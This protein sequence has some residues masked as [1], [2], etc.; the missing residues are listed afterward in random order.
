VSPSQNSTAVFADTDAVGEAIAALPSPIEFLSAGSAAFFVPV[1]TD[2]DW[3]VG[4]GKRA[5]DL[6]VAIPALLLLTPLFLI[7]ALLIKL[8]SQGPAFFRQTR[9]GACGRS[10]RIL[11]F[12]TMTVMEN[13][14]DVIQAREADPRTTRFGQFL[15]RTSI[16]E[17]PQLLNVVFGDMSLV[18]PRPHAEA[19]DRYY[20]ERIADYV[21]RFA[22]KPGM[23]GWAQVNGHRGPTPT[24]DHM[25]VRID[26]DVWYVRNASFALD[27]KILLKTPF[28]I[29]CPRNAF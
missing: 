23:T 24:V 15:R 6:I 22:V 8:D 18:G 12:R 20:G 4:A 10:F 16:D 19:H 13:G 9:S 21:H 5:F 7:V 2:D 28:A 14:A 11:K 1:N 26:H 17:M 29:F 3:S 25:A 27:L